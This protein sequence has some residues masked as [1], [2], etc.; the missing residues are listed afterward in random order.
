MNLLKAK[1]V[2]GGEVEFY[3]DPIGSGGEKIVFF[4]RDKQQVVCFF[5]KNLSDRPERRR[6]IE[7]I[8]TKYNVTTGGNG[9]YWKSHFCWPTGM[10]DGDDT[11]PK[12]FLAQHNIL[13]PP[14]AVICPAYRPNFFF[15]DRTGSV[16]EKNGKWF[17]SEKP[18]KLLPPD[19]KGTFLTYLQVCTKMARSV[20]RMHFAGLAHSDLSN[21]NV[22]IDPKNGDAC[23]IDI[24]SLVVPGIAPPGVMGTP[25]Y[26]APEVLSGRGH[27]RIETDNH[28]LGV[29]IYETLLLRHPLIG[30]KVNSRVSPEEDELLSMGA[31]ALFVEHPNDN[32]NSLRP[33]PVVPVSRLGPWLSDLFRKTFVDGLHEP[34]K[35]P[36]AAD[37][38][39]GLYRTFDILHPSPVPGDWFI[40][41]PGMPL[42]CPFSRKRL[43]APVFYAHFYSERKPG[44]F[45]SDGHG[46]TIYHHLGLHVWHTLS[47]VVPGEN[48]ERK[49]QGF[50]CLHEGRWYLYNESSEPMQV[51]NG[52]TIH[53]NQHVEIQPGLELRVSPQANGRVFRFDLLKP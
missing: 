21:K 36:S 26:I 29:L 7:N 17:T 44:Q 3:P 24:D 4:T 37:W 15:K 16:R 10:I 34:G 6:R 2:G 28:A 19:E 42:Q 31:K 32:S 38:E 30:P 27:P 48:V 41:G 53:P 22:L 5:Y 46:L 1:L 23:L 18:R 49:R 50:F 33:P 43:T 14:L 20:R 40:L 12:G 47:R 11:L 13:D 35:R 51:V 39:R 52:A 9:D 25:G 45:A 8:L